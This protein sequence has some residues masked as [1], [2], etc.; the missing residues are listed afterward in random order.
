MVN[1]WLGSFISIA[2]QRS[3]TSAAKLSET[4]GYSS[5][6]VSKVERG[7]IEPSARAFAL[8]AYEVGMSDDEVAFVLRTLR[9]ITPKEEEQTTT[10]VGFVE[11]E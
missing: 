11:S 10:S 6:Y 8:I 1:N 5:S 9:T 7:E 3:G 4:I 2:R